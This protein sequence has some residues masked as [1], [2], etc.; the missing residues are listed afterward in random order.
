[1]ND[2]SVRLERLLAAIDGQIKE[3]DSLQ[4]ETTARILRMARLDLNMR[5]HKISRMELQA[6]CEVLEAPA[7]IPS[8]ATLVRFPAPRICK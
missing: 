7:A 5:V 1:M 2:A 6:F 3:L 8:R 4:F